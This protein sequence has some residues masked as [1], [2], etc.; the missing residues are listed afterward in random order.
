M[1][2]KLAY[3]LLVTEDFV[4]DCFGRIKFGF[5]HFSSIVSSFRT[6]TLLFSL[7]LLSLSLLSA[8]E[9]FPPINSQTLHRNIGAL[10]IKKEEVCNW[11]DGIGEVR[12]QYLLRIADVI[13]RQ[14]WVLKERVKRLGRRKLK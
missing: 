1:G 14:Q 4:G 5:C 11:M 3:S 13:R 9:F 12:N 6:L 10:L 2:T 8:E 7:S